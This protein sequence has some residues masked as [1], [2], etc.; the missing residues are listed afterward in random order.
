MLRYLPDS[1]K[2]RRFTT[3]Q[4]V[5]VAI[6]LLV[7]LALYYNALPHYSDGRRWTPPP[8]A[9]SRTP[10]AEWQRRADQVKQAFLHAYHGYETHAMPHDEIRPL[11][12]QFKDN[13]N[14]WG[15]TLFDSLDTMILMDLNDEFRRAL[16]VV[17]KA[18]FMPSPV[19][20]SC[21]ILPPDL[22]Y[23]LLWWIL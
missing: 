8:V 12:N 2:I 1:F 3:R 16:P 6:A 13:F 22:R 4:L 9:A 14:G 7:V 19:R 15:V 18:D 11:S 21:A 23:A 17:E 10:P 20:H 5:A